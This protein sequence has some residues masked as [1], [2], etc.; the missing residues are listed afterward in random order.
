MQFRRS[1]VFFSNVTAL[2]LGLSA[3]ALASTA[4]GTLNVSMTIQSACTLTS[5]SAV[6]FGTAGVLNANTD[7]TGNLVVRCTNT[8]PLFGRARRRRRQRRDD[9]GAPHDREQ[10]DAELRAVPRQR[11]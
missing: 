7:A 5:S 11:A 1:F 4:N 3:P 2:T 10:R 6:A 8:T 9:R